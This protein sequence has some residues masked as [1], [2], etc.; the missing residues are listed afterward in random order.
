MRLKVLIAA[1]LLMYTVVSPG[2]ENDRMRTNITV[3]ER[4]IDTMLESDTA[5]S[6]TSKTEGIY[7]SGFGAVFT[8]EAGDYQDDFSG[9]FLWETPGIH[10]KIQSIEKSI[11][12]TQG[13]SE[14][15]NEG[16]AAHENALKEYNES[17][18]RY[19]EERVKE[20][21][22]E[23]NRRE[24][25]K[26]ELKRRME[27]LFA[28]LKGYMAD[29]GG[30]LTLPADERLML[31]CS[32]AGYHF[33]DDSGRDFEIWTTGDEL[34]RLHTGKLKRD[35]FIEGIE[36]REISGSEGL[37][38]D[39]V[40]MNNILS[41]VYKDR[42][43]GFIFR[44]GFGQKD[45]WA[46]YIPGFGALFLHRQSVDESLMSI[47]SYKL[48]GV[49]NELCITMNDDKRADLVEG[50]GIDLDELQESI[51]DLLVTYIPTLKS[52]KPGEQVVVVV[53]FE[54]GLGGVNQQMLIFRVN[55]E[56]FQ[57][58]RDKEVIRNKI[59]VVKLN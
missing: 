33:I 46:T 16:I 48:F 49:S 54:R 51:C 50:E 28:S 42:G 47:I 3:Q 20:L 23:L 13:E 15:Y 44:S 59:E 55:K 9:E 22:E 43:E 52:V 4:I 1:A 39:I 25:L 26:R 18:K 7:I 38:T 10:L 21:E 31:R 27:V 8:I 30:A 40:I 45:S 2:A 14:E 56:V 12:K 5:F 19:R 34:N 24:E 29:Y 17:L 6:I 57:Q 36:V 37:P 32:F 11:Q 35:K 58:Y 53:K 41:T